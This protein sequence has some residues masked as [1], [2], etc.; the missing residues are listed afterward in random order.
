MT[1]RGR[2]HDQPSDR[3]PGDTCG[4]APRDT[5]GR[6]RIVLVSI[7]NL[8]VPRRH[9]PA[10]K[11][12][13]TP[14]G[15]SVGQFVPRSVWPKL[16]VL[17]LTV[18]IVFAAACGVGS[19]THDP[20]RPECQSH[21]SPLTAGDFDEGPCVLEASSE[22]DVAWTLLASWTKDPPKGSMGDGPCIEMAVEVGISAGGG[23]WCDLPGRRLIGEWVSRTIDITTLIAWGPVGAGTVEQVRV[24]FAE[25]PPIVVAPKP[26]PWSEFDYWFAVFRSDRKPTSLVALNSTGAEVAREDVTGRPPSTGQMPS[27]PVRPTATIN[28]LSTRMTALLMGTLVERE[29]CLGVETGSEVFSLVW[30]EGQHVVTRDNSSIEVT[31]VYGDR[32]QSV[33]WQLGQQVRIGGGNSGPPRDEQ[34]QFT[35]GQCAAPY[36]LVGGLE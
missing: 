8:L 33:R 14:E 3:P 25:G 21:R 29:G 19:S 10:D 32:S 24:D 1:W 28:P 18:V 27:V 20:R 4:R 22:S 23:G 12:E 26:T 6:G 11:L 5:P 36:F 7:W 30:S 15:Q 17:S 35:S 2:H 16:F 13:A 31:D 9:G 34:H